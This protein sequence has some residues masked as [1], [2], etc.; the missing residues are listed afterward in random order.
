M[1]KIYIEPTVCV[2]GIE[3]SMPIATSGV[4]SGKGIGWG[5]FDNSGRPAD[6]NGR[7]K[8]GFESDW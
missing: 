7:R 6:S 2:Y 4:T 3:E 1:K 8:N 5:G